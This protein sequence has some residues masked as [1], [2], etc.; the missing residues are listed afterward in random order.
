MAANATESVDDDFS[1]EQTMAQPLT[2]ELPENIFQSLAKLAT[3]MGE[4]PERLAV[5]IVTKQV[6]SVTDDPLLKWAGAIQSGPPDVAQRHD[7]YL[8]QTL[9][10][11]LRSTTF[12]E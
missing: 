10:E 1:E 3:Q 5:D 2:I 12:R 8:G 11:D 4:T 6:Q 7:F 9:S